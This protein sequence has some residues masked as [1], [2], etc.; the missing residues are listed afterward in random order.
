MQQVAHLLHYCTTTVRLWYCCITTYG[1]DAAKQNEVHLLRC[2][3]ESTTHNSQLTF[4]MF[5]WP[6][7]SSTQQYAATQHI[8]LHW[9]S[10]CSIAAG[11]P[12]AILLPSQP[13]VVMQQFHKRK[14]ALH[15]NRRLW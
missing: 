11:Y 5:C 1:C 13:K 6:K 7:A 14:E 12:A 9:C 4:I 10:Q 8:L 2:T 15:H 3:P